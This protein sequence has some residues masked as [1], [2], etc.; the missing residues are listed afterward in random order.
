[1][2]QEKKKLQAINDRIEKMKDKHQK[3]SLDGASVS[4]ISL[5][6]QIPI[7]LIS[8]VLVGAGI[9]YIL[10]KLFDF[11]PLFLVTF[12]ILGGIAGIVNV[13]RSVKEADSKKEE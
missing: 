3:E 9:G 1:V 8:G 2:E 12:I 7:E 10:D 6:F 11:K 5:A 13:A 4:D